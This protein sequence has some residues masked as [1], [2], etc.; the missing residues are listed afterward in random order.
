MSHSS[1]SKKSDFLTVETF[2][3][4]AVGYSQARPNKLMGKD[5]YINSTQTK[6]KL[7]LLSPLMTT[8]GIS[9]FTD[10]ETGIE[11]GRYSMNLNFQNSDYSTPEQELFKEKMIKLENQ[12]L[13]DAYAN[14]AKWFDDDD[15]SREVIKSKFY[16][17]VKYPKVK[18][19]DGKPTKKLDMSKPPSVG[20][21]V[22]NYDNKWGC[23]VYDMEK[24]KLFPSED[25]VKTPCDFVQKK[26]QVIAKFQVSAIW[27]GD[28]AWGVK[29]AL[30][31]CFVQPS[32][33]VSQFDVSDIALPMVPKPVKNA[34]S[35]PDDE[36][37]EE[38][39]TPA[40]AAPAKPDTFVEDSDDEEAHLEEKA[41][42]VPEPEPEPVAAA[43]K[44]K[45]IKKKT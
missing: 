23:E 8:W 43:P 5:I 39:A 11:S 21:K 32:E 16:P 9:S 12:I 14:R 3:P 13:D 20:L 31:L 42:P 15:L 38:H 26:S 19:P 25:P 28:K 6:G 4:T 2:N 40:P 27:T 35:L 30:V 10:P 36:E 34:N 37:A 44:K 18:G 45:V 7:F 1:T 22:T 24:N 17:I 41:A 29:I 33:D